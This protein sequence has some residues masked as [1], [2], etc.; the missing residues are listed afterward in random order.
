MHLDITT[1]AI[2]QC[3]IY[4][5][6]KVRQSS[7]GNTFSLQVRSLA[8]QTH[9]HERGFQWRLNCFKKEVKGNSKKANSKQ[10]FKI[11]MQANLKIKQINK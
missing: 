7:N 8:S 6:K 4:S 1:R 3:V 11:A 2:G 9:L 10:M 5:G